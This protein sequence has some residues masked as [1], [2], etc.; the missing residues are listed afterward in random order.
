MFLAIKFNEKRSNR[1]LI[2]AIGSSLEE[3]GIKTVII[4]RDYE[5]WGRVHFA[6]DKLEKLTLDNIKKSKLFIIETSEKGVSMDVEA[7]Y[8]YAKKIPIIVIAKEGSEIPETIGNLAEKT[9]FYK[10]TE[11]LKPKF[12]HILKIKKSKA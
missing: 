7:E 9:I 12:K 2:E 4:A 11:D 6:P 5:K 10:T 3:A 8:A 1:K